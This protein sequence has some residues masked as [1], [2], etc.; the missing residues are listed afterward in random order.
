MRP[1]PRHDLLSA[2][3]ITAVILIVAVLT[4][5]FMPAPAA[6]APETPASKCDCGTICGKHGSSFM[7]CGLPECPTGQR[8]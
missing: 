5:V 2:T 8:H 4:L 1:T 7:S 3:V 6:P